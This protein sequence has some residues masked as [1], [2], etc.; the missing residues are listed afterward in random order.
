[1]TFARFA[2]LLLVAAVVVALAGAGLQVALYGVI[3]EASL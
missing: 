2:G 3:L 1:M